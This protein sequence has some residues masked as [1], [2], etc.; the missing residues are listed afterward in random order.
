[1]SFRGAAQ[2]ITDPMEGVK[3]AVE[4]AGGLRALARLLGIAHP[5]IV[6]WDKIPADRVVEI[7][8]L[9]GIARERLRPDLYRC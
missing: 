7:E 6:K 4:T 9:T 1:M 5:S 3:L 2:D 8:R